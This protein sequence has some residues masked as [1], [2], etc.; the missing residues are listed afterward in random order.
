MHIN[1]D[2]NM[3]EQN[4]ICLNISILIYE[5]NNYSYSKYLLVW[6]DGL[7]LNKIN[8]CNII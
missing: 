8:K 2:E 7:F 6:G 3:T 4:Q 5:E 1:H